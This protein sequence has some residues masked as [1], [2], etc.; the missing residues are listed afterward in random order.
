MPFKYFLYYGFIVYSIHHYVNFK[1]SCCL[2]ELNISCVNCTQMIDFSK[3]CQQI[4]PLKEQLLHLVGGKKCNS[5]NATNAT[6]HEA[7]C[8]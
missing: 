5:R 7:P 4:S 3:F 6:P 8:K 1:L 2:L